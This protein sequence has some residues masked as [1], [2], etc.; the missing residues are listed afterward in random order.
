MLFP[1]DLGLSS[2][3]ITN[4][5]PRD[6]RRESGAQRSLESAEISSLSCTDSECHSGTV[7]PL[8]CCSVMPVSLLARTQQA[9]MIEQC[10]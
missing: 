7:S 4:R 1:L 9:E 8:L 6:R 10:Q 3:R 2:S 5:F